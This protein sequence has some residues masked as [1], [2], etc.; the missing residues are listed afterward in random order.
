MFNPPVRV[1]VIQPVTPHYRI[2][3]FERLGAVP[4]IE[5][6]VMADRRGWG[7]LR[8]ALEPNPHFAIEDAPL[9]RGRFRISQPKQ[10][11]AATSGQ[12]DLL[13]FSWNAR[14]RELRPA[15]RAARQRGVRTILWGHGFSKREHW[16]RRRFRNQLISRADAV[17]VYN[18]GARNALID[19]G[20]DAERIFVALNAIDQTPVRAATKHWLNQP[21]EL[22][23][24]RQ[25][26]GIDPDAAAVF[27]ARLVP[28][29]GLDLL[30]RAFRLVSDERPNAR[31][32]LIGD[33][34]AAEPLRE[35]ADS[36]DLSDAVI[37]PGAIYDNLD[38]A[39]WML[40]AAV[41]AYPRAIGL[42]AMHVLGYGLPIITSD[43]MDAHAPE[44][45][46]LR[47]D[48][49]ALFYT[50]GDTR[51]FAD[52]IL[53]LMKDPERRRRMSAAALDA[54]RGENGFTLDRMVIG[55]LDAFRFVLNHEAD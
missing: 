53:G 35:L 9:T 23:A 19:E 13:V 42:S 21:A 47:S 6:T 55:F 8:S 4:G 24:F 26:H 33:G 32:I 38:L 29:R 7:S 15:L 17:L 37:M 22:D 49:N 41:C 25:Q 48:E 14:Y 16:L 34:P 46:C 52:A 3:V 39:P 54:V 27:V 20:Y 40:S 50:D 30:I 51:A 31:L 11:D 28:G 1:G 10:L 12:F 5:L 2:P 44:I 36:L 18:H 45:E 43:D